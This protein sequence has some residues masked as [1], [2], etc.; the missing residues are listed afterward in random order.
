MGFTRT[1]LVDIFLS[2]NFLFLKSD[3][4]SAD[5]SNI[6]PYFFTEAKIE[7]ISRFFCNINELSNFFLINSRVY[8]KILF[9]FFIGDNE[10]RY[11]V[12]VAIYFLTFTH[13]L[14]LVLNSSINFII[15]CLMGQQFHEQLKNTFTKSS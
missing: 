13:H 15:Y 8:K 1:V 11:H 10:D 4:L 6:F 9:L 2:T 14:F 7:C 3:I 12:P 5:L